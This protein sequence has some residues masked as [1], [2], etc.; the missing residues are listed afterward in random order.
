MSNEQNGQDNGSSGTEPELTTT[1]DEVRLA[2]PSLAPAVISEDAADAAS[3]AEAAAEARTVEE[4]A[5]EA[6]VLAGGPRTADGPAAGA[7]PE[8][9]APAGSPARDVMPLTGFGAAG[10]GPEWARD[11]TDSKRW[12]ELF[13]EQP[14]PEPAESAPTLASAAGALS[15]PSRMTAPP[16]QRPKGSGAGAQADTDA[17]PEPTLAADADAAQDGASAFTA[18]T[19]AYPAAI[20]AQPPAQQWPAQHPPSSPSPLGGPD[21]LPPAGTVPGTRHQPPGHETPDQPGHGQ[22]TPGSRTG[23]RRADLRPGAGK[24]GPGK[25]LLIAGAIGLVILALL[26]WAVITIVNAVGRAGSDPS[27]EPTRSAAATAGADGIIAEGV[28]P[29]DLAAGDCLLDFVD[30]NTEVTVVT[31]A[32]PHNAQLLASDFYDDDA[33]YPG[34]AEL[35][36]RAQNVCDGV[37][38]NQRAAEGVAIQSLTVTPT[39]ASWADGDRRLDCF[40][41]AEDGNVLSDSLLAG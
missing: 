3:L 8:G 28:A 19:S 41:V 30:A 21:G 27:G 10:K 40:A 20:P 14:A 4:E 31:C 34:D 16:P 17:E 26:I 13:K 32:T 11:D 23:S 7:E 15:L 36:T 37:T 18:K 25:T 22:Q 2:E 6:A 39:T 29:L 35:A 5:E 12:D 38:L 1:A 24:G 9:T 33:E